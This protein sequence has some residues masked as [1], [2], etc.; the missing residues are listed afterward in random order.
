M[1]LKDKAVIVS[2]VGPGMGRKLSLLIAKEGGKVAIGASQQRLSCRA[3]EGNR[4]R[5]RQG[6]LLR[7]RCR[8]SR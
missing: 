7:L 4:K 1:I 8:Q 2:G 3:D 6:R 5:R